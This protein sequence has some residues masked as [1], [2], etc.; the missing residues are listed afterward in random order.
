MT[1]KPPTPAQAHVEF[2]FHSFRNISCPEDTENNRKVFSGHAPIS[3]ILPLSD[4]QNVREYL[5]DAEGRKRKALTQVHKAI[6][7]TLQ[8]TPENFSIL[9]GG[10][11]IVARGYEVDE[12]K[13]R[14]RLVSPSIING[15][16]TRGIIKDFLSD[17]EAKDVVPPQVHTTYELIVTEDFDLIAEISISRNFQN[18]VALLSIAGRR[19][20]LEELEQSLQQ[21]LPGKKIKKSETDLQDDF[22]ATER[23]LQVITALIPQQL[24]YKPSEADNPNKVY[25]YAMKA[26]CLK[27]FQD[28]YEKTRTEHQGDSNYNRDRELYQFFLDVAGDAQTLYEKWEKHPGFKGTGLRSITRHKNEIVDVPDGIVFPILAALSA[29]FVKTTQGWEYRPPA[30]FRD[31]DLILAAAR[32]YKEIAGSNPNEMGK[33]KAC[34]SSLF[35]ITKLYK[36]LLPK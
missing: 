28:L 2:P 22:I 34:Y 11:V 6:R 14:L 5:V 20:Q 21:K 16:Q 9:N 3:S 36:R 17:C 30:E 18:D 23:L 7:E 35:E 26:R 12:Q 25:T 15:S 33:S 10:V 27:D 19:G 1:S 29:F 13:K 8:K 32:V 4:D 24:W 31:E